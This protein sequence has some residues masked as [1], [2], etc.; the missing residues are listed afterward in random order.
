MRFKHIPIKTLSYLNRTLTNLAQGRVRHLWDL[1]TSCVWIQHNVPG[2]ERGSCPAGQFDPAESSA[3]AFGHRASHNSMKGRKEITVTSPAI[4][5]QYLVVHSE[6]TRLTD[7]KE[8]IAKQR[9]YFPFF[10]LRQGRLLDTRLCEK[11]KMNTQ[12]V[13]IISLKIYTLNKSEL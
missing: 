1:S 3:Q 11:I 13:L 4:Y 8:I 2:K 9:F 12:E 6:I 10:S 5:K 7:S